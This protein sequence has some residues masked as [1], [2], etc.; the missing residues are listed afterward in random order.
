MDDEREADGLIA[1]V[2]SSWRNWRERRRRQGELNG[3][4]HEDVIEI[5]ADCGVTPSQL[6][7]A[8]RSGPQA[9]DELTQMIEA[10]EIDDA[11]IQHVGLHT[12]NDMK[13]LCA[14]CST[15]KR[16]RRALANGVASLTYEAFCPN[17]EALHELEQVQRMM[18]PFPGV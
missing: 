1:D 16:C 11:L 12:F 8:V 3:L 5:A 18:Q 7:D 17:A 9:A 6:I 13:R 14:E 2:I 10:L 4:T 15:K